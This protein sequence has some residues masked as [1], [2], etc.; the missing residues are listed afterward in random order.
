M[1]PNAP[2]PGQPMQPPMMPPQQPMDPQ[3]PQQPMGQM[4]PMGQPVMPGQPMPMPMQAQPTAKKRF[5]RWLLIVLAAVAVLIVGIAA[6]TLIVL[7]ATSAASSISDKFMKDVQTNDP[8]AAYSLTSSQFQSATSES[9]LADAFDQ[10]SPALQGDFKDTNVKVLTESGS[11]QA[12]VIY[13]V[14]TSHGKKYVRITLEKVSGTWQV[15]NFKSSDS[16]LELTI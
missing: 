6:I 12:Q 5:P 11:T 13:E 15:L 14:S 10:V 3:M 8:Q 7:S 4:P 1:D 9:D 2:M 16:P